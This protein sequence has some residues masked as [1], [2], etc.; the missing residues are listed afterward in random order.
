MAARRAVAPIMMAAAVLKNEIAVSTGA[1]FREMKAPARQATAVNIMAPTKYHEGGSA[2][3][4][5][6]ISLLIA[7]RQCSRP[8]N[9]AARPR[10]T[11]RTGSARA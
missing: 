3:Q 1:F 6:R 7:R 4:M 2:L 5:L 9:T 10:V 8:S 11:P